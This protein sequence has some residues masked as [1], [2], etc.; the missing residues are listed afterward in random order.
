[1]TATVDPSG[2]ARLH[3]DESRAQKARGAKQS[4]N[5]C[6]APERKGVAELV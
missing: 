4:R 1:L 3:R 2:A 6:F 5:D